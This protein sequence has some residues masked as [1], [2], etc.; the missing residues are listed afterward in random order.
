MDDIASS[1]E[2]RRVP[3]FFQDIA[4]VSPAAGPT[5]KNGQALSSKLTL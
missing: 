4:L 3:F 2:T 1:L 5:I